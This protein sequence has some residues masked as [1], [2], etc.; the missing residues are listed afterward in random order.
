VSVAL[1]IKDTTA[2]TEMVPVATEATYRAVWQTGAKAL[3]L[4]WVEALQSG[5]VITEERRRSDCVD[6]PTECRRS[7]V[8]AARAAVTWSTRNG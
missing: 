1:P 5:V 2:E 7:R 6:R 4:D 8:R 3:A